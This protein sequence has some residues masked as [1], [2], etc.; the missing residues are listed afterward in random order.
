MEAEHKKLIKSLVPFI[1][2][3]EGELSAVLEHATVEV[4]PKGKMIFKRAE[5]NTRVYWLIIGTVDLVDE[6]FEAKNR[7]PAKKSR[8][9]PLTTT[10]RT[11]SPPLPRKIRPY[12][13][14]TEA[15]W[16]FI[17]TADP[18]PQLPTS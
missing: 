6:K 9:I 5:Q 10:A 3:S 17:W 15:T 18:A 7:R 14:A 11:G 13:F 4:I 2:M 8:E 16:Q 1:H 12:W